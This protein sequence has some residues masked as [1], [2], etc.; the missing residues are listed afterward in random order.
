M[1]GVASVGSGLRKQEMA[2]GSCKEVGKQK[3]GSAVRGGPS[4]DGR[5]HKQEEAS[6]RR[7]A[8]ERCC[9]HWRWVA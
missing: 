1:G 9:Q 3:V 6:R 7:A 2:S 8:H 5:S 4:V